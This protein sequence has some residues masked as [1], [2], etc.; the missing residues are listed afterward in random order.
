M[1][2]VRRRYALPVNED[3][4]ATV[5]KLITELDAFIQKDGARV[6]LSQYGGGPDESRVIATQQGYLRLGIEFLRA[7]FA[8]PDAKA[9]TQITVDLDYLLTDDS[10]IGFD[11]FERVESLPLAASS[12]SSG[13]SFWPA[14][15]G[16]AAGVCF[17][18]L[19]LVGFVTV[20]QWL[21]HL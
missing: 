10:D 11:W 5:Q 16:I 2:D 8:P 18:I 4:T 17:I 20:I 3:T 15:F 13:S 7:A 14:A 1:R 19:L 12:A 21:F 9:P 6:Q